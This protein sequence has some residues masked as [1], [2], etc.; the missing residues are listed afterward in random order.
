[1][2]EHNNLLESLIIFWDTLFKVMKLKNKK[3]DDKVSVIGS[4]P[5]LTGN[6]K[7]T[8]KF[9]LSVQRNNGVDYPCVQSDMIEM[10]LNDPNVNGLSQSNGRWAI[11]FDQLRVSGPVQ[12]QYLKIIQQTAKEIDYKPLGFVI[13][14]TGPFTLGERII[15]PN[16][17]MSLL[18]FPS[19]IEE[20]NKRIVVPIVKYYNQCFEN[21]IIRIDEP[22]VQSGILTGSGIGKFNL[23]SEF[24]KETWLEILKEI[25]PKNTSGIHVCGDILSV[26]IILEDLPH[27]TILSHEFF[28]T[29]DP[30]GRNINCYDKKHLQRND[31]MIGFGCVN[32]KSLSIESVHDIDLRMRKGVEKFGRENIHLNPACGFGGLATMGLSMTELKEL[33]TKKLR[34][35]DYARNLDY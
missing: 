5:Y 20:F 14:V 27:L 4:F 6:I 2:L 18:R 30:Y 26:S 23:D 11:D 28:T 34:L 7:Q 12:H 35:V 3:L 21:C 31:M 10:F 19:L 16:T 9:W 25:S 13:P 8:I 33:I 29:D 15:L 22:I 24:V 1:M 32:S 17:E